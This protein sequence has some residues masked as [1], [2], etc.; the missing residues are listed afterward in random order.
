MIVSIKVVPIKL[1]RHVRW[2]FFFLFLLLFSFGTKLTAETT[3]A[4]LKTAFLTP[5]ADANRLFQYTVM[6]K[7]N[8]SLSS[9][10]DHSELFR[11]ARSFKKKKPLSITLERLPTSEQ[12]HFHKTYWQVIWKVLR[13]PHARLTKSDLSVLAKNQLSTSFYEASFLISLIFK[14]ESQTRSFLWQLIQGKGYKWQVSG[15]KTSGQ[16]LSRLLEGMYNVPF[17]KVFSPFLLPATP[18]N[19]VNSLF[20]KVYQIPTYQIS[21]KEK[22]LLKESGLLPSFR[23]RQTFLQNHPIL[24][25]YRKGIGLS[26]LGTLMASTFSLVTHA[27]QILSEGILP[28]ETY[29]ETNKDE[30][31]ANQ[32]RLIFETTPF[33]HAAIQ[34]KQTV[35][36]YGFNQMSAMPQVYYMA[37]K[38]E[39][40]HLSNTKTT[41]TKE[42][43]SLNWVKD[44]A[45]SFYQN[46]PRSVM[47]VTL[48]LAQD[49]VGGLFRKLEMSQTKN[50]RNKTLINDCMSMIARSLTKFTEVKL[51]SLLDA[52]PGVMMAYFSLIKTWQD[53]QQDLKPIVD[54]VY[55][56]NVDPVESGNLRL[57]LNL[58]ITSIEHKTMMLGSPFLG[59]KRYTLDKTM[60]AEELEY[61]TAS[62]QENMNQI[63]DDF[64]SDLLRDQQLAPL[65]RLVEK[66]S[67]YQ[68][69]PRRETQLFQASMEMA[70]F[71]INERALLLEE[72][73]TLLD[74]TFY[75]IMLAKAQ[76]RYLN[77]LTAQVDF[78]RQ[79]F[80]TSG[81]QLSK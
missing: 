28:L 55:M 49:D 36:S 75:D 2:V 79:K 47:M 46:L 70:T 56:V 22:Q 32:V 24:L 27:W 1:N 4:Q 58:V 41:I 57:F 10:K 5:V 62:Q 23:K 77:E 26:I 60:K 74:A 64:K 8:Q 34:I 42:V 50:Y 6:E 71:L 39:K 31:K 9:I 7:V 48:N 29:R 80:Q 13:N 11:R 43:T 66:F 68:T 78:M 61:W 73:S 25:G 69:L 30:L 51:P 18:M 37:N 76:L 40:D 63:L 35:Y 53:F 33:P 38:K 45:I 19:P 21:L 81:R 16:K 52:S 72:K 15:S 14:T 59:W 17:R 54:S 12:L 44:S 65:I 3:C 20:A 67:K